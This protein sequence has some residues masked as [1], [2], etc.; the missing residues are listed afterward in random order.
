[1]LSCC[2]SSALPLAGL[3]LCH[4]Q[5]HSRRFTISL[6]A[7]SAPTAEKRSNWGMV[8]GVRQWPC[9]RNLHHQI[10]ITFR[11]WC[12]REMMKL[13][14]SEWTSAQVENK[15]QTKKTAVFIA[16]PP[17]KKKPLCWRYDDGRS[18][19]GNSIQKRWCRLGKLSLSWWRYRGGGRRM[20]RKYWPS[21]TTAAAGEGCFDLFYAH[22]LCRL[23]FSHD[24]KQC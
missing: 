15:Q 16:R 21:T 24:R 2:V 18:I 8:S 7:R 12:S 20:G 9:I 4:S 3:A 19:P 11:W 1:M 10:F 13:R 6:A 5:S 14:T 23:W 17:R 22:H